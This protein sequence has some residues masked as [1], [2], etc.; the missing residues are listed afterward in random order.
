MR[1][2]G[3]RMFIIGKRK[4]IIKKQ[5]HLIGKRMRIIGKRVHLNEKRRRIFDLKGCV[6]KVWEAD[7]LG[8]DGYGVRGFGCKKKP[9]ETLRGGDMHKGFWM[10][11]GCCCYFLAIINAL[12]EVLTRFVLLNPAWVNQSVISCWV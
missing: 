6:F 10:R 12:L 11:I 1:I 7:W 8:Y 3:K 2:I 4:R 9:R 5:R